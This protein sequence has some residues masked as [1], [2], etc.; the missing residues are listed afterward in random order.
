MKK[1]ELDL[2]IETEENEI[3]MQY[4]LETLK[5]TSDV[6]SII[7]EAVLVGAIKKTG[8]R[9]HKSNEVRTK[10]KQSFSGSFGQR[11]SL[12]IEDKKLIRKL[13]KMGDDIFL[14]VLSYF[15]L[16]ALYLDSG[17][18]SK[19]A[20]DVLD[21]LEGISDNLFSRIIEPLKDMH[22]ISKYF[23]HDVKLRYRKRGHPEKQLVCLTDKTAANLTDAQVLAE[24]FEIDAVIIRYHSKTGNGRLH[25]RGGDRF[26]SFGYATQISLV[27]RLL[28]R[29]ISENLHINN[30]ID[31]EEGT[32]I[33]LRVKKKVLPTDEVVKYLVLGIVK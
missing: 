32:F 7:S 8:R 20:S 31:P 26:Y 4:G 1:L 17:N 2:L 33:K 14:E 23:Q 13:N 22:Q 24:E 21:G 16:E 29:D 3:D 18:L 6:V 12:E 25:I 28:R 19:E 10:L 15:I 30:G 11:F 27:Q 5:G 9:T